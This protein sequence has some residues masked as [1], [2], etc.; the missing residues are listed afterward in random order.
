MDRK[1]VDRRE[2]AGVAMPDWVADTVWWQVYPLGFTGAPARSAGP[3]AEPVVPRL[4]RIE[5]WLD[6]AAGLGA[7]GIALGPVFAAHTHG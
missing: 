6:Y 2:R 3:G 1:R 7:T 5:P 4:R